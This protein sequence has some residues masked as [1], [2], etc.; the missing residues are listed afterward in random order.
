MSKTS[1]IEDQKKKNYIDAKSVML[2]SLILGS[3]EGI[4]ENFT[5]EEARITKR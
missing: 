1:N 5:Q 4:L 2:N 3:L